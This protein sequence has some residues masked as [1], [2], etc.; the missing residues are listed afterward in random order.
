FAMSA[1]AKA[2]PRRMVVLPVPFSPK[3]TIHWPASAAGGRGEGVNSSKVR[4]FW[5]GRGAIWT[6]GR[7]G[8][9]G[10]VVVYYVVVSGYVEVWVGRCWSEG[11]GW[12][13]WVRTRARADVAARTSSASRRCPVSGNMNL[14]NP[15]AADASTSLYADVAA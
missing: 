4:R 5:R 13:G 15:A 6:R 12:G 9:G 11:G 14:D 8:S 7:T 10:G 2:T 1:N 3:R